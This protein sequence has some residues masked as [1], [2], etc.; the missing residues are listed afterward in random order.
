MLVSGPLPL[1]HK[2]S[3][4]HPRMVNPFQK[5]FR[6]LFPEPSEESLSVADV[7]LQNVFLKN[8][9]VKVDIPADQ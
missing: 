3:Q 2:C 8:Q 5:A 6:L 9:D 7:T 1:S 4:W